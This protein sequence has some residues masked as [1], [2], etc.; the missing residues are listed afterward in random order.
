M[1]KWIII[2]LLG[3]ILLGYLGFDIRKAI[4]ASA[5]RSNLEYVKE[6]TLHVWNKYLKGSTM[7]LWEIIKETFIKYIW[8]PALNNLIKTN[9]NQST[10]T[11]SISSKSP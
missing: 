10:T 4:D 9:N 5:T 3:L 7:Y 1:I 8:T 2:A 6:A 11:P